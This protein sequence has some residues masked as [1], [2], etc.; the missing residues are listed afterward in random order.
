MNIYFLVEGRRTEKKIYPKW[1][2]F[3][4]PKLNQISFF[5]EVVNNNYK[6]VSGNGFPHLLHKHLANS[7]EDVNNDGNYDYFVICLDSDEFSI[8][9]RIEEVNTYLSENNIKLEKDTKL[10]IIVQNKCIETWLLG[11]KKVFKINPTSK[12]LLKCINHYNVSDD[13]PENMNKEEEYIGS[14]SDYHFTYLREMLSERNVSYTKER[15]RG[16]TEKHYL[17]ELISRIEATDDL[18]SFKY[19]IDFCKELNDKIAESNP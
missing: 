2:S 4:V 18:K 3:L 6:L 5:E 7:I 17:E 15:P 9:E 11:N 19:F 10:Q 12:I 1:L 13:N 14:D 16:V 8:A